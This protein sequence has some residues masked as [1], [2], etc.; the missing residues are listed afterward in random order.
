MLSL[1]ITVLRKIREVPVP[2]VF[3][4]RREGKEVHIVVAAVANAKGRIKGPH[5]LLCFARRGLSA[6]AL[7]ARLC[8]S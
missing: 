4:L 5:C 8:P 6:T 7:R 1:Y 3:W 2:S